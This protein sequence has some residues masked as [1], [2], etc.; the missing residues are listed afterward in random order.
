MGFGSARR[1]GSSEKGHKNL[2]KLQTIG[3]IRGKKEIEP[4]LN[5]IVGTLYWLKMDGKERELL[6]KIH[7]NVYVPFRRIG[8]R[9]NFEVYTKG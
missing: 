6:C 9:K 2:M 1:V 8:P 3:K 4:N 5:S 7:R